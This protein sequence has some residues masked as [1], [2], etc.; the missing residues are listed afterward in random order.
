MSRHGDTGPYVAW[1]VKCVT[2]ETNCIE[3]LKI[4]KPL[5]FSKLN[6]TQVLEIFNSNES[7]DVLAA[8]YNITKA[9]IYCIKAG[10][11]W[12]YLTKK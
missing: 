4:G 1:N 5:I 12:K 9:H 8:K 3:R 2:S 7:R 10:R 11:K 6:E